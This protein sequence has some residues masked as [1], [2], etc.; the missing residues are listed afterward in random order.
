MV[1]CA[2]GVLIGIGVGGCTSSRLPNLYRSETL[3]LVVP[4]R[5]PES[6]VKL[7]DHRSHR[8][9]PEVDHAAD[10]EPHQARANRSPDFNL[11][12]KERADKELMEDIVEQM[13]TRDIG[14][15]IIKGDCVPCQSIRPA[16]RGPRCA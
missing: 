4:Q 15:D 1:D 16:I 2:A 11:Y 9:P 8:R 13:R 6:Y 3:I 10:H 14:I 7:D 12:P 5:V